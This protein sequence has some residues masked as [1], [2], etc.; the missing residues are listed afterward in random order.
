M[1]VLVAIPLIF[2]SALPM[3]DHDATDRAI[4]MEVAEAADQVTVVLKGH[5]PIDQK[6]AYEL[7][8][9]G[10][11]TS[12]HKGRTSLVAGEQS[13]LS[14]MRMSATA[15]WC[16]TARVTE[17]DGSTYEYSEGICG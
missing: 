11:S 6:V 15:P 14:T 4:S 10:A 9:E 12:R 13:V 17:A 7:V 16:I 3:T 1:T 5:S 8:L 2:A